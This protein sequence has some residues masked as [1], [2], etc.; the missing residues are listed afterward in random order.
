MCNGICGL[1]QFSCQPIIIVEV[2]KLPKNKTTELE[3]IQQVEE[4]E[5]MKNKTEETSL[6]EVEQR[7]V[8]RRGLFGKL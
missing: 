5:L 7:P 1:C 8:V 6:V 4:V 3:I 2:K